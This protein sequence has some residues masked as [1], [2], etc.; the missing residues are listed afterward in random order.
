MTA[1]APRFDVLLS[2]QQVAE[3][4]TG[5]G[6]E[7]IER[8]G[9]D[10]SDVTVVALLRGAVF[11]FVDLVRAMGSP[12]DLRFELVRASSYADGVTD[13]GG[14]GGDAAATESRG[15]VSLD[16][17]ALVGC[18]GRRV[19]L[20]DDIIDTGLTLSTLDARLRKLGATDVI[21]VALLDKRSRR[22]VDYHPHLAGFEI[23]DHFVVGY[24]LD[25]DGRYRTLA[26]ICVLQT[27]PAGH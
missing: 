18:K 1:S 7:L 10:L 17:A 9:D 26:D 27:P 5:L 6:A 14:A 22:T 13:P 12:T 4:V 11:F 8:L 25:C 24:G 21:T 3:R 20:V 15:Q 23:P 2:R 16:A 19:V